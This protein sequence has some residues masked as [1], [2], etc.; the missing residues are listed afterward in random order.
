MQIRDRARSPV[1]K[2]AAIAAAFLA[3]GLGLPIATPSEAASGTLEEVRKR[4]HV[5]CG[6]GDKLG[7]LSRLGPDGSWTGMEVEFCQAVAAAVLGDKSAVRFRP[8]NSS[9]RFVVLTSGDID[10]L[11]RATGDTFSREADLGVRFAGVLLH[12]GQGFLVK[13]AVAV[14]S[15]LELS[16]ASICVQSGTAGAIGIE[17][18]FKARQMRFTLVERDKW[19]ELIR[20]YNTDVCTLLTSDASLLAIERSQQPDPAAHI[21]LPEVITHELL[22]PVVRQGDDP[23][24]TIVRWTL[25]ALIEAE[26]LGLTRENI[27]TLRETGGYG[28]RRFLGVEAS[29]GQSLGLAPDWTYQIVKQVGHYGEMFDRNLGAN[30]P[31]KLARGLNDLWSRGG[32]LLPA[33]FR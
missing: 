6:V 7:G 28:I 20:A 26:E 13:R 11:L 21:L 18:Y 31:F 16:G 23:W 22:G 1:R 15:V 3:L 17:D 4:G 24:F 9:D 27:D 19:D 8:V 29:L 33:P 32:I 25:M 12:D 10:V 30:S 14:S 2:L 5:S